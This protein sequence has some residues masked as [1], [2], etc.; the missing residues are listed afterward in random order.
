MILNDI[1]WSTFDPFIFGFFFSRH[2]N[3]K[4]TLVNLFK[5]MSNLV[6]HYP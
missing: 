6:L 3:N 1:K 4:A 5:W 2:Y